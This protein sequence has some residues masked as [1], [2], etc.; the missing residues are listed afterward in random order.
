VEAFGEMEG[1]GGKDNGAESDEKSDA[2]EGDEGAANTLQEGEK[3][4][5]PVE[6]LETGGG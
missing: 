6:P 5:G 2:V 1:R 3:E 4:A